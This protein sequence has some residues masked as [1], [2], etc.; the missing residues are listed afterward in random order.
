[1]TFLASRGEILCFKHIDT[2]TCKNK[3]RIMYNMLMSGMVQN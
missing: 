3:A 1:M 2:D